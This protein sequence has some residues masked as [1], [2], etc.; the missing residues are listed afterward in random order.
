MGHRGSVSRRLSR[1]VIVG[2]V[3]GAG[4]AVAVSATLPV[5]RQRSQQALDQRV[6][7]EVVRSAQLVRTGLLTGSELTEVELR[8]RAERIDG[9]EVLAVEGENWHTVD[10]VRV[11][12]RVRRTATAPTLLGYQ[13]AISVACFAQVVDGG[14]I[15]AAPQEISCPLVD[16]TS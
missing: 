2:A 5:L 8:K 10:E 11:L 1:G 4:L 16:S 3:A 15:T 7:R 12:F 13:Q 9:V 14:P 6:R